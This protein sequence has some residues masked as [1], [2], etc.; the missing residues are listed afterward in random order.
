M[1]VASLELCKKLY[2][3][4]GWGLDDKHRPIAKVWI[5]MFS[6]SEM[7]QGNPDYEQTPPENRRQYH[8]GEYRI[9]DNPRNF[10]GIPENVPWGWANKYYE[11]TI[12][13][14]VPAYDLGYLLR[15]LPPSIYSIQ[16]KQRAYLWTRKDTETCYAAWYK[17][18]DPNY[19][20]DITSEHGAVRDTPEDAAAMLAIKL[21]KQGYYHDSIHN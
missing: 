4:S 10:V 7:G 9:R 16:Y 17:V 1:N 19:G 14:S 13:R 11:E 20:E 15:K 12:K 8:V 2:A 5:E 6:T 21:F 18:T 3:L